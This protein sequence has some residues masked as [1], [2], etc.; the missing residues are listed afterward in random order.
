[1]F[2][3]SRRTLCE[4]IILRRP[5]VA[6]LYLVTDIQTTSERFDL[7]ISRDLLLRLMCDLGRKEH[8]RVSAKCDV[9]IAKG[10]KTPL[11]KKFDRAKRLQDKLPN[12][13]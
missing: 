13:A 2:Q 11:A 5:T 6:R 7:V 1:M 10:V 12:M 9:C 3:V 8:G 4:S